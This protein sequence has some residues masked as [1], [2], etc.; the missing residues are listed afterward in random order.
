ME[1]IK[2]VKFNLEGLT[3]ADCAGRIEN[4][5][6]NDEM[7]KSARVD[8]VLGKAIIELDDDKAV[9]DAFIQRVTDNVHKIEDIPVYLEGK[10]KP[11]SHGHDH[12]H[13]HIKMS[14]SL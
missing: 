7:I 10:K 14:P 11:E 4:E 6:N 5:L 8:M 3:C 1:K 2:E 13:D 9:D 12:D